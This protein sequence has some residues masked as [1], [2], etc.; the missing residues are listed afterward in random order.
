M[1]GWL[2]GQMVGVRM[3][4]AIVASH[5]RGRPLRDP[6]VTVPSSTIY[7]SWQPHA[8]QWAAPTHSS[9][10]VAPDPVPCSGPVFAC[11]SA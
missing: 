3:A 1:G 10:F 6:T 11:L 5:G 4:V 8:K 7:C 2:V 9:A